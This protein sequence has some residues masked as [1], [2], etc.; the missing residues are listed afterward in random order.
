M[1]SLYSVEF[2]VNSKSGG[3]VAITRFEPSFVS[4]ALC[5]HSDAMGQEPLRNSFPVCHHDFS[6]YGNHAITSRLF[7]VVREFNVVEAG[8]FI[9][10][11]GYRYFMGCRQQDECILVGEIP[12]FGH[13]YSVKR[14]DVGSPPG[15]D[16]DDSTQFF[17]S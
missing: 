2:Q 16:L 9:Q 7:H 11:P 12:P 1:A 13:M 8:L 14:S 4:S 15:P 6:R 3:M 17:V 5:L 10:G